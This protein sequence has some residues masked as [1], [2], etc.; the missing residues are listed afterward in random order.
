M[1]DDRKLSGDRHCGTLEAQ[2]LTQFKPPDLEAALDPGTGSCEDHRRR[3]VKQSPQA[4]V[5]SSRDMAVIVDL[6]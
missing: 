6:T 1:H 3:F 5:A 2:P 4:I